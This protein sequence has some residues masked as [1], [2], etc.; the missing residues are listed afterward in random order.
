MILG[1][2]KSSKKILKILE[3]NLSEKF[4]PKKNFSKFP[5][6]KKNSLK[7]VFIKVPRKNLGKDFY[8]PNKNSQEKIRGKSCKKK[9]T[10]LFIKKN[11]K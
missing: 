3:K 7:N 2:N 10:Y 6:N 8:F 4:L 9:Y 1:K 5:K 11:Q